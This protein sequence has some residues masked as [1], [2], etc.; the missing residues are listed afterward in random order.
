MPRVFISNFDFEHQLAGVNRKSSYQIARDLS[1]TWLAIAK[2][3]DVI[4]GLVDVDDEFEAELAKIGRVLK[5]VGATAKSVRQ[6]YR[7][8]GP[9]GPLQP[10]PWGWSDELHKERSAHAAEPIPDVRYVKA[11]NSRRFSHDLERTL[12][13]RLPSAS[14]VQT[15]REFRYSAL[16][17]ADRG[18]GW[19]AKAEFSMSSRERI[20]SRDAP[21]D[22]H[23]RWV[24]S[25]INENGVVF[26]EPLL[27]IV[28]EA[29]AQF[30][31]AKNGDI[32]RLGLTGLM[33]TDDG[34]FAGIWLNRPS[35]YE[36]QFTAAEETAFTAARHI[37][38]TGYF[39]P[40]GIDMAC[41]IAADGVTVRPLQDINA[42]FTMGRLALGFTDVLRSGEQAIWLFV[43]WGQADCAKSFGSEVQRVSAND[44]KVYRTSP[45]CVDGEDVRLGTLLL[46]GSQQAS[47]TSTAVAIQKL[48]GR[49]LRMA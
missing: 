18:I 4:E 13:C 5:G 15:A 42:R 36:Q 44:V 33:T 41:Y 29:G 31:I 43:P 7:H 23:S 11:V 37:A 10:M 34:R 25:R 48:C 3:E 47:L 35:P 6:G 32:S 17:L 45:W 39:G 27:N 20:I 46:V 14:Q 2:P 8:D 22:E 21:T 19:I 24:Q 1:S 26:V 49:T 38:E 9:H 40:L 28:E 12:R 30:E 16:D